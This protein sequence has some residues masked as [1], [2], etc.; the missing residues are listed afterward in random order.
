M[1]FTRIV[2]TTLAALIVWGAAASAQPATTAMKFIGTDHPTATVGTVRGGV[3]AAKI[4]GTIVGSSYIGGTTVDV[5][6][7][8]LLNTVS[9]GQMWTAY[10]QT[11]YNPDQNYMRWGWETDWLQRYRRAAWLTV[12]MNG[13]PDNDFKIKAISTAIWR[14]FTGSKKYSV[15]V[16]TGSTYGWT[17]VDGDASIWTAAKDWINKSIAAEASISASNLDYWKNFTVLSDRAM[18]KVYSGSGATRKWIGMS[19]GAQEFIMT[20]EPASLALL[21]TGLA[22]LAMVSRRRKAKA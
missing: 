19:G 16:G 1:K 11:L 15:P 8:D 9:T 6:C 10:T 7:V 14:T 22:G 2:A 5:V 12:Q 4:G 3:Y 18:T 20:P 17:N 21:A 13:L